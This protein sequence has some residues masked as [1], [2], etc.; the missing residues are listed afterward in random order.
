[1]DNPLQNRKNSDLDPLERP[2]LLGWPLF[3]ILLLALVEICWLGSAYRQLVEAGEL[4]PLPLGMV[5]MFGLILFS[6]GV[7]YF[8]EYLRLLKNLKIALYALLLLISLFAG[9]HILLP[10]LDEPLLSALFNLYPGAVIL[11]F[12]IS[13]LWWRGIT[14]ARVRIRPEIAW[15]RFQVGLFAFLAIVFLSKWVGGVGPGLGWFATYLFLGFLAILGARAAYIDVGAGER[16]NP[17][18]R[19]W[20][21][22]MA[23]LLAILVVLSAILGSLLTGQGSLLLDWLAQAIY[24]VLA[25]VVF[26]MA[27]PALII[28]VLFGGFMAWLRQALGLDAVDLTPE[29]DLDLFSLS[30]F[31]LPPPAAEA[32]PAYLQSILFWGL[33]TI[34]LIVLF[35]L[36]RRRAENWRRPSLGEPESLLE[37]G[38]AG[39]LLRKALQDTIDDWLDRLRPKTP[40]D[41]LP[42]VRKIYIQLLNLAFEL[43]VPRLPSQTTLEFQQTIT[44]SSKLAGLDKEVDRI[45]LA[46]NRVR[47]GEAPETPDD[48]KSVETAWERISETRK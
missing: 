46:Y 26:I 7:A 25:V 41:D 17:L 44:Q 48:T 31:D 37:P 8:L 30:E 6:F 3:A 24:F 36:L 32:L 35:I 12:F 47:Y 29:Q 38:D 2:A 5:V 16:V 11:F 27:I 45:T 28:G 10:N 40:P 15:Q 43:G 19:R 9:T 33:V 39:R 20:I 34:G 4:A 1:M 21:G 14:L 23:A 22:G 13:W 42:L 18:N